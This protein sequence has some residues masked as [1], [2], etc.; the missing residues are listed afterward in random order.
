MNGNDSDIDTLY[1]AWRD[2]FRRHDVDAILE[3]VTEDYVLFAPGAPPQMTG[4]L[5]PRL[6]AALAAYEIDLDFEREERIVSGDLAF[7]RGWDVQTVWPRDGGE[8]RRQRQRVFLIL[9]R[10]PDA[11]WRFA[12]GMSL[13]PV[14][15]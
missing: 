11:V 13:P 3:L 14:A 10:G 1:S 5:R 6:E 9:R 8:R 12:R 15:D 2:A 7:E 4:A